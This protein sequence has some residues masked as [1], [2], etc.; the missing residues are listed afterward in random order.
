KNRIVV[1]IKEGYKS[2]DVLKHFIDKNIQV[3]HFSEIL[4]SLNDIFIQLV[5]GTNSVTRSF[6]NL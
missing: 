6:Q 5:N 1:K 3:E 4:P 2:N